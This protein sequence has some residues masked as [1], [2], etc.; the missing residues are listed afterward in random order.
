MQQLDII[1]TI[2]IL[3]KNKLP[4][5]KMIL[6]KSVENAIENAEKIGYPVV[7]KIFS[8]DVIHKSDMGFIKTKIDDP[9]ELKSAYEDMKK[10]ITKRKVKDYNIIL[11]KMEEG[12]EIIIGLKRDPQFGP[13]VI[14]GLGGIFVEVLKDTSLR[15][16]PI[17]KNEALEM[18]KE[19]KSYPILEGIRGQKPVDIDHLANL[20]VKVSDLS[21]NKK[22]QEIDFNPVIADER[23]S[24][25]VDA[26]ILIE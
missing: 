13:V 25:I 8:K 7:L 23:S 2:N 12:L 16:L 4:V 11:Q 21:K 14:F 22:I 17:D 26:R 19:I 9:E 1:K 20:I 5:S 24:K 6:V 10:K 15:I 3:E 18:I